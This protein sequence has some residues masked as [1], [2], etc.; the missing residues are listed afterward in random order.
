MHQLPGDRKRYRWIATNPSTTYLVSIA[1][2]DYVSFS[3]SYTP[4]A[5]GTLPIDYYVY[6]EDLA[7]AQVS[8]SETPAMMT[9]FANT[10][11]E[12]P[13]VDDKYGMSSFSLRRSDG[14]LDQYFVRLLP[15]QRSAHL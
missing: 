5:G 7:D 10:F 13:F 8:F 3:H 9:Y 12:Y 15:D 6:P 11:G 14:A 4:I 1:A 2:S